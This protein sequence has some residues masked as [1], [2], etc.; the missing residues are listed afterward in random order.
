MRHGR[1]CFLVGIRTAE[2]RHDLIEWNRGCW[3]RQ[4]SANISWTLRY[5]RFP[6][7]P[8]RR[9]SNSRILMQQIF[10]FVDDAQ[11]WTEILRNWLIEHAESRILR[12]SRRE[13]RRNA[14]I[15]RSQ[16]TPWSSSFAPLFWLSPAISHLCRRLQPRACEF[17]ARRSHGLELPAYLSELWPYQRLGGAVEKLG[18]GVYEVRE[19]WVSELKGKSKLRVL[20]LTLACVCHAQLHLCPRGRLKL[21]T[22]FPQTLCSNWNCE[23]SGLK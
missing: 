20:S 6:R 9:E 10:S 14:A 11:T 19:T 12:R 7:A 8:L 3:L 1:P 13:N 17:W 2:F 16:Q 22:S 21:S 18:C 5:C 15:S 23:C 4:A